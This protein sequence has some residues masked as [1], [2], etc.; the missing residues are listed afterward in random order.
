MNNTTN[1]PKRIQRKRTKGWRKPDN[2]VS[3]C[4]PGK[5]GN[6]FPWKP[7]Y[8]RELKSLRVTDGRITTPDRMRAEY[9]AKE[10]AV[11]QYEKI[12]TDKD[13]AEI[14]R[15]LKGKNLMCF[16]STDSPC[17]GDVLLRIAN[18]EKS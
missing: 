4:R 15:E 5:W 14:R 11:I 16:C 17:H 13:R 9:D 6:P 8:E 3:V 10:W 2:T 7:D 18:E 1:Q 12:L